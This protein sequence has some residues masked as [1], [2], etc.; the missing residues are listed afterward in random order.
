MSEI[1]YD[2]PDV[3]AE[4]SGRSGGL[5]MTAMMGYDGLAAGRRERR[6]RV[7]AAAYTA[8]QRRWSAVSAEHVGDLGDE[9]LARAWQATARHPDDQGAGAVRAHLESVLSQ[10]DPETMR[11]YRSWRVL[12]SATP[13]EAM[14]RAL[15]EREKRLDPL[16][17][18]LAGGQ[19]DHLDDS[20]LARAWVAATS[21]HH[22]DAAAAATAGQ[23][24]LTGRLPTEMAAY[25]GARTGG[26]PADQ[27]AASALGARHPRVR[28]RGH[29]G[30]D[31]QGRGPGGQGHREGR[32]RPG[33]R[34]GRRGDQRHPGR[35]LRCPGRHPPLSTRQDGAPQMSSTD[36]VA[37]AISTRLSTFQ[38][39]GVI[40]VTTRAQA[41]AE[42]GAIWTAGQIEVWRDQS[43]TGWAAPC[44]A[45]R[46]QG[47][48]DQTARIGLAL[49]DTRIRDAVVGGVAASPVTAAQVGERLWPVAGAL[50]QPWRT[51]TGTVLAL[52]EWVRGASPR[53]TLDWAR[54]GHG[55]TNPYALA[56]L[57]DR[58]LVGG[59]PPH[60][61]VN[62]VAT[63]SAAGHRYG[64]AA[65]GV[66]LPEGQT[67]V[68]GADLARGRVG[69]QRRPGQPGGHRDRD[70]LPRGAAPRPP[71]R[72]PGAPPGRR[73][74]PGRVP[75]RLQS[76]PAVGRSRGP[77]P[78]HQRGGLWTPWTS[79]PCWT[80]SA[81]TRART[82]HQ[83]RRAGHRHPR[84]NP[85]PR[86]RPGYPPLTC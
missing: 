74:D 37:E 63:V 6:D 54:K 14:Q 79:A 51:P 71:T 86:H 4:T 73:G 39:P 27:A 81:P 80:G 35:G 75:A 47:G 20:T 69:G 61:W 25:Q 57:L 50:P 65:L 48:A 68:V 38:A 43:S 16:W 9:D 17:R 8:D 72:G 62:A 10:R 28:P 53:A 77:G 2:G 18:A 60:T 7:D 52:T 34:P 55:A 30:A 13:G 82:G 76:R 29:L 44:G 3:E 22:P 21:A 33:Q 24:A 41:Q 46:Q 23:H 64:D 49:A 32:H 45:Q 83:P 26:L 12:T 11:D 66:E 15:A 19:A 40:G 59:I 1:R 42:H 56:T 85:T 58:C 5:V 36:G 67:L 70:H 84:I 78:R 31:R